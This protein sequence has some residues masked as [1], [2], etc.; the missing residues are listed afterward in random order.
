MDIKSFIVDLYIGLLNRS[1][2]DDEVLSWCNQ[3]SSGFSCDKILKEF[4]GCE[5]FLRL[6]HN[7]DLIYAPPGHFYSPIVNTN[8]PQLIQDFA[9]SNPIP[10]INLLPEDQC[11]NWNSLVP[12]LKKLSFNQKKTDGYRYFF[13]NPSYGIG[14]ASIYCAMILKNQPKNI[15]ENGSGY[16]SACML[17]L[18]E[19]KPLKT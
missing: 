12:F 4:I 15:I 7:K 6:S 11:E 9:Y 10:G 8:E 1:P 2:S 19:K 13:D 14:D 18:L 3:Y 5:E 17:D 16:S